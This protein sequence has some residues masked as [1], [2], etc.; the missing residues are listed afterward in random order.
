MT[1]G[2]DILLGNILLADHTAHRDTV[3]SLG[4]V[5]GDLLLAG[6]ALTARVT[7]IV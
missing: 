5:L 7:E 3:L 6:Q 1:M 4:E 2:L